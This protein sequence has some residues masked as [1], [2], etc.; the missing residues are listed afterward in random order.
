[1][2]Y[3]Y[4]PLFKK[5]L[6]LS[7]KVFSVDDWVHILSGVTLESVS[8][9]KRQARTADME[10]FVA[11]KREEDTAE[12]PMQQQEKNLAAS[13]DT[14]D[15]PSWLNDYLKQLK[16]HD[17]VSYE[18]PAE[19]EMKLKAVCD[20]IKEELVK[21]GKDGFILQSDDDEYNENME[22]LVDSK[23]Y[24]YDELLNHDCLLCRI[25]CADYAR[26]YAREMRLYRVFIEDDELKFYLREF[27]ESDIGYME[28]DSFEINFDGLM[29]GWWIRWEDQYDTGDHVPEHALSVY[30]ELITEVL[31]EL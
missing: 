8:K 12:E 1:M 3:L 28:G 23:D 17:A 22:D 14:D 15:E 16:N 5:E 31:P 18:N 19:R 4:I 27:T 21:Q 29:N 10:Q 24:Y 20:K 30:L 26:E 13:A 11:Y 2:G 7:V 25:N 9:I 6:N